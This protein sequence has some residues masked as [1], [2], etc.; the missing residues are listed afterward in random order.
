M[1]LTHIQ[2]FYE[3][4]IFIK[5]NSH[6]NRLREPKMAFSF[7][8]FGVMA[9]SCSAAALVEFL[10]WFFIYS[11]AK[12][13]AVQENIKKHS[14]KVDSA[15]GDASSAKNIKKAEAK[16]EAW[17]GEAGWQIMKAN[18][19][20]AV[21]VRRHLLPAMS[22]T[23]AAPSSLPPTP[24]RNPAPFSADHIRHDHLLQA[25]SQALWRPACGQTA[26]RTSQIPSSPHPP[27]PYRRRCG[28]WLSGELA[29][30]PHQSLRLQWPSKNL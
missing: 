7:I 6:E 2:E 15:R 17:K 19:A 29:V 18:I 24:I 22:P 9:V 25:H 1:Q 21:I 12:Y 8:P 4:L 11:T 30:A 16:L 27:W 28:R 3:I 10:Q 5:L 20:S 14:E 13:K 26:L 23:L